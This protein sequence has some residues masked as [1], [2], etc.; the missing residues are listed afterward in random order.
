LDCRFCRVLPQHRS[1]T[2]LQGASAEKEND[3]R[4]EEARSASE[5][6]RNGEWYLSDSLEDHECR[7][8]SPRNNKRE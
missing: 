2:T 1:F 7:W 5:N 8:W 3:D 4:V 6:K